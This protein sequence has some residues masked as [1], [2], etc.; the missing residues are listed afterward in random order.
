MTG[1]V[2]CWIPDQAGDDGG[3]EEPL[4][5]EVGLDKRLYRSWLGCYKTLGKTY[6]CHGG[7]IPHSED[8]TPDWI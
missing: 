8:E 7:V 5:E 3:S 6:F 2:K 1:G 4:G